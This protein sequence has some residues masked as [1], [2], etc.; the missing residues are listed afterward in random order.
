ML[1]GF[2]GEEGGE[3]LMVDMS[4]DTTLCIFCARMRAGCVAFGPNQHDRMQ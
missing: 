2:E 1:G 3:G 4:F